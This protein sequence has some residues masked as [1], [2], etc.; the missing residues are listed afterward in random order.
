MAKRRGKEDDRIL[1]AFLA[2]FLSII[3]FIIAVIARRD[4]DYV[5]FYAKQSLVIFVI[6][7]IAGVLSNIFLFIPIMGNIIEFAL[8]ILVILAWILSWVYA[9]SGK[10]KDIP[11][12]SYFADKIDL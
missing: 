9:L 1:F 4:D 11:I 3:G 5:M 2:A 10:K 12:I 6:G 7:C 8:V